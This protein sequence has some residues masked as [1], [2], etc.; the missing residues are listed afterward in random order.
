V[1]ALWILPESWPAEQYPALSG[2]YRRFA[3]RSSG[4]PPSAVF[5]S[6]YA[7]E[8]CGWLLALIRLGGSAFVIAV[9]EEF[10]W[11]GFL[12]RWLLSKDIM[13]A[14]LSRIHWAAFVIVALI[15]GL[16]HDRW[17]AGLLAGLIYGAMY[18]RTRDIWAT[19]AAHAVTNLLLGM[20]VLAAGAYSFW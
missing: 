5:L 19:A 13:N 1:F 18:V 11:R 16:E 14:D 9:I 10:F 4:H 8:C 3:V 12:Y 2:L 17:L 6:P 20:Y 7:P 15:F